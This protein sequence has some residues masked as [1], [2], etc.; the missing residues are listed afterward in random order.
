MFQFTRITNT[1]YE[2]LA[3]TQLLSIIIPKSGTHKHEQLTTN[4]LTCRK[5]VALSNVVKCVRY[6]NVWKALEE[7]NCGGIR[8]IHF[9]GKTLIYFMFEEFSLQVS[10]Y[11][12]LR[13]RRHGATHPMTM[14]ILPCNSFS[15]FCRIHSQLISYIKKMTCCA[16][17][18]QKFKNYST[19]LKYR[20]SQKV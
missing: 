10:Q 11:I 12:Y 14:Q 17:A 3:F 4:A 15:L 20:F 1:P 9:K 19:T 6:T 18:R 5:Y 16:F 8:S 2:R 13:R 7:V